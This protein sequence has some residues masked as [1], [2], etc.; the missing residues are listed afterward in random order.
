MPIP[1]DVPVAIG[2]GSNLGDRLTNLDS[3]VSSL[4]KVVRELQVSSVYET[5]PVGFLPQPGFLNACCVGRTRL[6]A[7]QFMSE[8]QDAERR[9]GRRRYGPRYG[10]RELDLDLLLYGDL[11]LVSDHLTVPHPRMFERAFVLA[12][13]AEIAADWIVPAAADRPSATVAELAEAVGQIGIARTEL[14]L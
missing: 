4:R 14:Q 9:A 8:L 6:S 10:P 11:T 1:S 3:G 7:R 5:D 2:L 12:P 13:L